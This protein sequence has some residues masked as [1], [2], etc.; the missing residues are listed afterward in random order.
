MRLLKLSFLLLLPLALAPL[1]LSR[2]ST[3]DQK[4]AYVLACGEVNKPGMI[5]FTEGMTLRHALGLVDGMTATAD[6]SR[7]L[8]L[9]R[10]GRHIT[11]DPATLSGTNDVE[12]QAGD[13]IAVPTLGRQH[14]FAM[15]EVNR[16]GV[17]EFREGVTLR[18][19]AVLFEGPTSTASLART[20]IVRHDHIGGRHKVIPVDL[21]ALMEGKIED[22]PIL[23]DDFIF[24]RE[25]GGSGKP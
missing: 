12:L 14:F 13:V 7:V 15:G 8:V 6:V 21:R 24:I 3:S 19:A 11:I 16:P 5:P 4:K 10:D 25:F 22:V 23:V 17:F 9:G 1:A 2:A 18:Q 20:L